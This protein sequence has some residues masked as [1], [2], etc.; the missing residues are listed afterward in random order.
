MF[1]HTPNTDVPVFAR[2]YA[3]KDNASSMAQCLDPLTD[4]DCRALF[5]HVD[6]SDVGG[7]QW[8]L[9]PPLPPRTH[10]DAHG[11]VGALPPSPTLPESEV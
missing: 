11:A 3:A 8:T 10:S 6:H 4:T 7:L 5:D 2:A 1:A 9:V